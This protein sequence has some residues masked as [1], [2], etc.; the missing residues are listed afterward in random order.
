MSQVLGGPNSVERLCRKSGLNVIHGGANALRFTPWYHLSDTEVRHHSP[1][2]CV[3]E[4][5]DGNQC[6]VAVPSG[7]HDDGDLERCVRAVPH[8]E[9]RAMMPRTV[10][11]LVLS[12]THCVVVVAFVVRAHWESWSTCKRQTPCT[13]CCEIQQ[14]HLSTTHTAYTLQSCVSTTALL[15]TCRC[16]H[17]PP[18]QERETPHTPS[19]PVPFAMTV[20]A[21][22]PQHPGPAPVAAV[23]DGRRPSRAP[24]CQCR[25]GT[26][27]SRTVPWARRRT[28][29][30]PW[31]TPEPTHCRTWPTRSHQ[32]KARSPVEWVSRAA[33]SSQQVD[34]TCEACVTGGV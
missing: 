29:R 2:G 30:R 9:Q 31:Q 24:V 7:G 12:V 16:H 17:V 3:A 5:C 19:L 15:P 25:T 28:R 18:L 22:L 11:S 26:R 34:A 21:R 4:C 13:A 27:S 23:T 33:A 8:A 32:S 10:Y 6:H 1:C 14:S 20:W